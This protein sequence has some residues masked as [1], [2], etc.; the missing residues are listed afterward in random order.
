VQRGS[1]AAAD[2]KTN[3]DENGGNDMSSTQLSSGRVAAAQ[4]AATGTNAAL[5]AW[6]FLI[7]RVAVG[8]VF[9][10]HGW[11]KMFAFGFDGVAG[12]FGSVGIPLPMIAAVVVT[13]LEL[14]GGLALIL[15]LGTRI[16]AA[17][18]AVTMV[19]ALFAVHLAN[20]F[21]VDAGGYELVLTLAA[22]SLFF[23]LSGPGRLSLDA[24][25]LARRVG[26]LA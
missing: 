18:L 8:F 24:R 20:G 7:L 2:D 1:S 16:V 3:D 17:L 23:A 19:V 10:M 25:L 15:G 11:Q 6:G 14:V 21:F 5:S 13:L 26:W 12:F 4:H 9:L 22:A